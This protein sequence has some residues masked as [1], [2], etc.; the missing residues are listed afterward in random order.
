MPH[1]CFGIGNTHSVPSS[2]AQSMKWVS[3]RGVY[4]SGSQGRFWIWTFDKGW[5]CYDTGDSLEGMTYVLCLEMDMW[6]W[7][8]RRQ[9]GRM[10]YSISHAPWRLMLTAW[11]QTG[12]V[13]ERLLDHEVLISQVDYPIDKFIAR[14][15]TRRWGLVRPPAKVFLQAVSFAEP[16]P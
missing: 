7:G 12:S 6:Y 3:L 5:G 15:S 16:L 14:W 4:T 1:P 10:F 13:I 9:R 11:P 2:Y 8:T